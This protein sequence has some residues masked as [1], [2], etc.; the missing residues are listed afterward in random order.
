MKDEIG[1]YFGEENYRIEELFMKNFRYSMIVAI[2]SFCETTLNDLCYYLYRSK[3]LLLQLDEVRGEGIERAKLYL[4]KV[5]LINFPEKDHDWQEILKLNS[6][7]NCIIHAEGDVDDMKS[8][9]KLRNIIKNT[10]GIALDK[11]IER[12]LYIESDYIPSII[13]SI[14]KFVNKVHKEAF[15]TISIAKPKGESD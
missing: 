5:C 12:F 1:E 14:E 3:G 11:S 7:R 15:K 6:I 2:Y 9:A 13:S 10:K 4:I 8:P